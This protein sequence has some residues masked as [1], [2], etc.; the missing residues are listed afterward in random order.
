MNI[1]SVVVPIYN[2]GNKL[3]KCITSILLQTFVNFEL[4]LVNDGSQDNSLEIC[5]KYRG[6]DSRIILINK[7]NEGSVAARETGLKVS[8]SEYVMFVDAD[9]WVDKNIIECLY[10]ELITNNADISVCNTYKVVGNGKLIKRKTQS[11]YFE[12]DKVYTK[13]DVKKNLVTSYFH[14]HSFP[15][16]LYAKLYKRDLLLSSG[17]YLNRIHYLGDDLF[18]N[19]EVFL[20]AERVK[21]VTNPLYYYR[22]GGY[23]SKYM[24]YLFDDM[25]NG[26]QIQK[27]VINEHFN[28]SQKHLNGISVMLLNTFKTCLQ[29]LF[30]GN[31]SN[32]EIKKKIVDYSSNENVIN[33]LTN[34]ASIKCFPEEYLSAIRNKNVEYLYQLGYSMHK[35]SKIRNYLTLIISKIS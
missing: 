10:N 4:I 9:D 33:C 1:V 3:D 7:K 29:N 22:T 5:G 25:T 34:E 35:K 11:I 2:S 32:K 18:Y 17:N 13:E 23:T 14:G 20:K 24:P 12:I 16:S 26:Y 21:V 6:E 8:T 30:Q 31:L 19:L 15:A 28:D 27:E